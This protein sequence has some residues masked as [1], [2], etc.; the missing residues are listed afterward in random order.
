MCNH[1]IIVCILFL[2]KY[3]ETLQIMIVLQMKY[4]KFA[5]CANDN[6]CLMCLMQIISLIIH[7]QSRYLISLF[8]RLVNIL[9][10]SN[11][12]F[13]HQQKFECPNKH[14]I[15]VNIVVYDCTLCL[16]Y[17]ICSFKSYFDVLYFAKMCVIIHICG[18]CNGFEK[19]LCSFFA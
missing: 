4:I 17:V 5:S 13:Q 11:I 2:L 15:H 6:K 12:F 14:D 16:I 19:V 7:T 10:F 18:F 9:I 3:Y 1:S 8:F